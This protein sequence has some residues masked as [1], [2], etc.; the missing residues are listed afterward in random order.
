[1]NNLIKNK[2]TILILF[3]VVLFTSCNSWLDVKPKTQEEADKFYTTEEGFKSALAGVYI[4]LG[5]PALYG[6]EMTYGAVGMLGQ[7]W[8]KGGNLAQ[9]TSAHY[10]LLRY[11]YTELKVT[12]VLNNFWTKLYEANINTNTL[13]EYTEINKNVLKGINYELIRGEALALRAF[14]HF[15]LLRMYAACNFGSDEKPSIPYITTSK[16]MV[17]PQSTPSEVIKLI[18]KDLDDA[19]KLLEKDPIFTGETAKDSRNYH[20]NYYAVKA[21]KARVYLYAGKKREA[22]A[23]AA[24]VIAAQQENGLFPWVAKADVTT[25]NANLLDRTFSS[26]H[27]FALNINKL[28]D[29]IKGYFRETTIPLESRITKETLYTSDDYRI[30]LFS[31][32]GGLSNVFSKF[33][34][35]DNVTVGD[36]VIRP[37]RDRMPIFRISEMYYIAAESSIESNPDMA[38]FYLNTVY[39]KRGLSTRITN[40]A[41][42]MTELQN[43]YQ[44]EF[45]GEGQLYFFHKRMK[46]VKIATANANYVFPMP[47]LEIEL[48]QRD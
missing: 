1:M 5:D 44:R 15:D 43:E 16:P 47:D 34:Q 19:E 26:E 25:T 4:A 48:G 30:K 36:A 39:E 24:S 2:I 8:S 10:L 33:W 13:L 27:I 12:E 9:A 29:N 18:L 40:P 3:G 38:M 22:L 17:T 21:L 45:L 35:M 31:S 42:L 23:A 20:F 41:L 6:R 11:K 7:E 37:K 28:V 14:I 46:T 32:D